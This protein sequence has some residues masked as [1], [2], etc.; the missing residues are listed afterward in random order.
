MNDN[1]EKAV[2]ELR[3]AYS[4]DED[5]ILEISEKYD[6]S[7]IETDKLYSLASDHIKVLKAGY[8]VFDQNK[9]CDSQCRYY[10]TCS[11]IN[12]EQVGYEDFTDKALRSFGFK[13]VE[14]SMKTCLYANINGI[15]VYVKNANRLN[16]VVHPGLDSSVCDLGFVRKTVLS[17]DMVEFPEQE[18]GYAGVLYRGVLIEL[19]KED[20]LNKLLSAISESAISPVK[21]EKITRK[22]NNSA[23]V[24]NKTHQNKRL[25]TA[26]RLKSYYNEYV[27]GADSAWNNSDDAGYLSKYSD[28]DKEQSSSHLMNKP[29]NHESTI[30]VENEHRRKV[31]VPKNCI[32]SNGYCRDLYFDDYLAFLRRKT[33]EEREAL[34]KKPY[35]E[36]SLKTMV[37]D[38]FFLEK[39][40]ETPFLDWFS[41]EEKLLGAEETIYR[42]LLGKRTNPERDTKY[43]FTRMQEFYKYLKGLEDNQP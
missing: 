38:T 41:S 13:L 43:Y 15:F 12:S 27:R 8:C 17:D 24:A 5:L 30:N 23:V 39:H 10:N 1:F 33:N 14:K 3:T 4:V 11:V 36:G 34:G 31:K 16:V 19:S 28:F 7:L 20:N 42:N 26:E 29:I 22:K 18:S 25:G 35:A 2:N 6:L 37:T 21:K 32:E 40:D 9:L